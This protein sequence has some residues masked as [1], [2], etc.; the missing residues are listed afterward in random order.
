[1]RDPVSYAFNPL[2]NNA[3]DVMKDIVKDY[4]E[5][6][7]KSYTIDAKHLRDPLDNTL[8][9]IL[10]FEKK[11]FEYNSLNLSHFNGAITIGFSNQP[12]N[13]TIREV[14]S[15]IARHDT[16]EM[17]ENSEQDNVIPIASYG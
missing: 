7:S 3:P 12:I 11:G 16:N 13:E 2:S 6:A 14:A 15:N 1:M 8:N 4:K 10:H 17:I 9:T 5:K